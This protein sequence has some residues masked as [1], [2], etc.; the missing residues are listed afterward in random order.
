LCQGRPDEAEAAVRQA[1]AIQNKLVGEDRPDRE[2]GMTQGRLGEILYYPGRLDEAE[3]AIRSAL[4]MHRR[5]LGPD[6]QSVAGSAAFLSQILERK[7]DLDEAERLLRE[8]LAVFRK[9]RAGSSPRPSNLAT[10]LGNLARILIKKGNLAE[11][12][13]MFREEVLAWQKGQ[14]EHS[15]SIAARYG[16]LAALRQQ[17]K[18]DEAEALYRGTLAVQTTLLASR[19][20]PDRYVDLLYL[21]NYEDQLKPAD[22]GSLYRE[23]LRIN[24]QLYS[25][26]ID[27]RSRLT[28]GLADTLRKQGNLAEAESLLREAITN[29]VKQWPKDLA[30]WRWHVYS[31]I[32]VLHGQGKQADA[33]R[34]ISDLLTPELVGPSRDA[35]LLE[36]RANLAGRSGQWKDA[37]ADYA[38]LI[39]M[40]STDHWPFH[41]FAPVLVISGDLEAYRQLCRRILARSSS[42]KYRD[43]Y[44]PM[45]TDCLLLPPSGEDLPTVAHLA[46]VAARTAGVNQYLPWSQVTEALAEYRQGHF[47]DGVEWAQ[48]ALLAAGKVLERDVQAYAVLAMAQHQ[49]KH[50][51]EARAALA[52]AVELTQTKLPQLDS[53]DLGPQWWDLLIAHILLREAH[54][55]MEGETAATHQLKP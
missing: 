48:R 2:L 18:L 26:R 36:V 38:Q 13:A 54:A 45:A 55:L 8:A 16:L 29:A 42:T 40:G 51:D 25:N 14:F 19:S 30:N 41:Q 11:A 53:G 37:A 3:T 4:A 52:K 5:L 15:D 20:E 27:Q 28:G 39:E 32:D 9:P 10:S 21:M 23:A 17:G 50:A 22:A 33:Y 6:N 1:L 12:E 24:Q 31:L 43:V 47:A 46:D 34:V 35:A 7:G 49:L 44:Q